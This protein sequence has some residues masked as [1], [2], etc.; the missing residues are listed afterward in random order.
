MGKK[1]GK[2]EKRKMAR[3]GEGAQ[4]E[5]A[6]LIFLVVFFFLLGAGSEETM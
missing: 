1:E 3:G 4:F 2:R 6:V 5:K